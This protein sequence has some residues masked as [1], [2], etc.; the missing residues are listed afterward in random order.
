MLSYHYIWEMFYA[1]RTTQGN[2]VV[3]VLSTLYRASVIITILAASVTAEPMLSAQE[4]IERIRDVVE[5]PAR[6]A[7]LK[8]RDYELAITMLDRFDRDY[9]APADLAIAAFLRGGA[10]LG[11]GQY[12]AVL[13][14]IG[15][16]LRL[17]LSDEY[18]PVAYYLKGRALL[19]QGLADEGIASLRSGIQS[20]PNHDVV[21]NARLMLAHGL[22]ERNQIA[23]ARAQLDTILSSD[24]PGWIMQGAM[25]LRDNLRVIGEPAPGFVARSLDGDE[26]DVALYKGRVVLLDFWASW[27]QPCI[28]ALPEVQAAY[29]TYH[30]R[31][32]DI[33]GISL[34]RN[35]SALDTFIQRNS[36]PWTNVYD[37]ASAIAERYRV[38]GIP[39]TFLL[40]RNGRIAA[41]D[42]RGVRLGTTI[43]RLLSE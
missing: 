31:G 30:G 37:G 22:V 15:K 29:E 6:N 24:G 7:E 13:P 18:V 41:V 26:V 14:A 34:D 40:D 2:T 12:D 32:F 9:D 39:K 1:T 42:P 43:E 38:T 19:E 33:V 8:L 23:P 4:S 36:M 5:R 35:R 17:P 3:N 11:L 25:I 20:G 10:L 28:A 21:S 16:A 27:C